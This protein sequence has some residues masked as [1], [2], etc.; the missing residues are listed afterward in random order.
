MNEILIPS[1]KV[2][3]LAECDVLVC[4]AG[5]AG[6]A[7]AISAARSGLKTILIERWSFPGGM[8]TAGLLSQFHTSDREKQV[9]FG[10]MQEL[11]ERGLKKG[12]CRQYEHFPAQHETHEFDIEGLKVLYEEMLCEAGVTLFYTLVTGDVIAE[13][14]KLKAVL[15]DTK[16]GRKAITAKIFIDATGDGD[17]AAKAGVPFDFGRDEDGLVQGMTLIYKLMDIDKKKALAITKE[18]HEKIVNTMRDMT[19]K[20]IFPPFGPVSFHYYARGGHPNMCP[21]TGNPLD[22]S[23]LTKC[24]IKA[25]KQMEAYV[26]FFRKNV[27]GFEN[28]KIATSAPSLGIRESRRIKGIKTLTREDVIECREQDDAV[29]H[30]FWMIDIHDPKGTGRTTWEQKLGQLPAGK[31]YHIPY[32]MMVPIK[33]SNLLVAGRCASSTHEA[34]ASVRVMSHCLVMGQG[35]G[36]AAGIALDENVNIKDI[37]IAILQKRLKDSG[38]YITYNETKR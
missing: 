25:R 22:E 2:P 30:G 35:A 10:I 6:C 15:C 11:I 37:D 5:P 4:G 3:V 19:K 20:G 26:D 12:Y 17:I 18:E 24:N 1:I 32:R 13:E 34:H 21:V 36:T 33:F 27:P 8:G 14:D 16:T 9:I 7:A 29:G 38:V 31:S 23:S 28:V